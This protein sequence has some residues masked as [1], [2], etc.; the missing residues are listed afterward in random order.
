MASLALGAVGGFLFGPIGFLVGSFIGNLLFPP[1]ADPLPNLR[2]QTSQ[3]GLMIPL[4]YGTDRLSGQVVWQD[5]PKQHKSGGKG[6][7]ETKTTTYSDSFAVKICKG[8]IGGVLRVW[9]NNTLIYDVTPDSTLT[10]Q[11]AFTL[12]LGV[13]SALPD[14]TMEAAIG[15][16]DVPAFRD[17]AVAVFQD[18]DLTP[19]GNA[20]PSLSFE[21]FAAGGNIPIRISTFDVEPT[22]GSP[23][24]DGQWGASYDG[25]DIIIGKYA[26]RSSKVAYEEQTTLIDGTVVT[27]AAT[28]VDITSPLGGNLGL[29]GIVSNSTIAM[30]NWADGT[31]NGLLGW[32]DRGVYLSTVWVG[33]T[34][35]A[36]GSFTLALDGAG[37]ALGNFI[38]TI[39]SGPSNASA[40]LVQWGYAGGVPGSPGLQAAIPR[41]PANAGDL[42]MAVD[43]ETNKI[44][45]LDITGQG[46][47][48]TYPTMWRYSD[49]M[50]LEHTWELGDLPSLLQGSLTDWARNFVMYNDILCVH[51]NAHSVYAWQIESDNTF[52]LRGNIPQNVSVPVTPQNNEIR[53]SGGLVISDDG[54]ISLDPPIEPVTLA[55]IV[56]DISVRAGLTTGQIDVSTLT[57]LVDGYI[58][59]D[60]KTARDAILPLQSVYFFDGVESSGIMKF[61]KRGAIPTLT[62]PDTDL[63]AQEPKSTPPPLATIV[64]MQEVDL[65]EVVNV[66]YPD[67]DVSYQ[68]GSQQARRQVTSSQAVSNIKVAVAMDAPTA[69]RAANVLLFGAWIERESLTILLPMKYAYLEPTD[70]ITA[71]GYI[72][73]VVTKSQIAVGIIQLDCVVSLPPL[74]TLFQAGS[75]TSGGGQT[76]PGTSQLAMMLLLDIPLI[77][78]GDNAQGLYAA[79]AGTVDDTWTGGNVYKSIDGGST[80][81]QVSSESTPAVIGTSQSALPFFG[82]SNVFDQTNSVTVLIGVGGGELSSSTELGVLNGANEALLGSEIIQFENADLVAPSTYTLSGLL[83][84]RRGTEWAQST[85]IVGESFVLMPVADVPMLFS[86]LGQV[87]EFK[88]VTFG[89][90]VAAALAQSFTDIGIRLR[91][92]SPV[93]LGG[94]VINGSGDVQ[95][96]WTRRTRIGGAWL[97][98]VDVPLSEAT[99]AYVVQIWDVT[100]TLCARIIMVGAT[101]TVTYTGS[102]QTTDFGGT[103]AHIYFTVAQMGSYGIG[104]QAFGVGIGSGG[105]DNNPTSPIAPYIWIPAT[106]PPAPTHPVNGTIT[107]P[108]ASLI[109]PMTIG[110]RFVYQFTT[111]GTIPNTGTI[112]ISEYQSA[113]AQRRCF[114]A[115]DTGGLN[116]VAKSLRYGTTATSFI[117][118]GSGGAILAAST[119]Y[120]F[121]FDFQLP[122]GQLSGAPGTNAE[123]ILNLGNV[124]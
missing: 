99:E 43:F 24:I 35:P 86:E 93:D 69:R 61:V 80:Y 54:V 55:S 77:G 20:L 121:I 13:E 53:L 120:Y 92:Y 41:V 1:K 90:S 62:I 10:S 119:T 15:V 57:D 59:S 111:G 110:Q 16:G 124:T 82:N 76:T 98:L 6:G 4:V 40:F 123:T 52:T 94:G 100:Y 106:P 37:L 36:G 56:S 107:W 118:A 109:I 81:S 9:G 7:A 75:G 46:Q 58:V 97:D 33:T 31:G 74:Y 91:P 88:P 71:R 83:R 102:Q 87:R 64:R 105:S 70:V 11:Q 67:V 79:M 5:T 72:L 112:A 73:R 18:L 84:G 113:A 14:P 115:T 30:C 19:Y 116:V 101:E 78:D 49:A 50:V 42:R 114:I 29:C 44:F 17:D 47:V 85:H 22:T 95:L 25:T 66:T 96:D 23:N 68:D 39:T 108:S 48:S 12:Y 26:A 34:N 60:Q 2:L 63:A 104:S 45:I 21:V 89:Q 51:I 38:Y 28:I 8:P 117:G 27:P 3:Y 65:P 122:N 103:Q 32:Y